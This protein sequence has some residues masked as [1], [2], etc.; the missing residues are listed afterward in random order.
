MRESLSASCNSWQGSGGDK[1][2]IHNAEKIARRDK[3]H[4]WS[5]Q[6]WGGDED[7]LGMQQPGG[8]RPS[9][10]F[11]TKPCP[12]WHFPLI[13]SETHFH[14]RQSW[15]CCSQ[16]VRLAEGLRGNLGRPTQ[17]SFRSRVLGNRRWPVYQGLLSQPWQ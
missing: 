13:S 3:W 10:T 5:S 7:T 14:L 1:G 15:H 6:S 8:F 12:V 4:C 2:G 9:C 11:W 17:V 16:G